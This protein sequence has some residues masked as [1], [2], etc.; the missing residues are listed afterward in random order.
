MS[1]CEECGGKGY[2]TRWQCDEY[3]DRELVER[4]CS[5]CGGEGKRPEWKDE[6]FSGPNRE[7]QPMIDYMERG[8]DDG[9][10]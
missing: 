2:F 8:Y 3:G 7:D 9:G 4:E 5:E 6:G 1:K 10:W